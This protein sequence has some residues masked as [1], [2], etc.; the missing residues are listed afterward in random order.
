LD[1][2]YSDR[3]DRG[4][5]VRISLPKGMPKYRKCLKTNKTGESF[6]PGRGQLHFFT[7]QPKIENPDKTT[8]PG[9]KKANHKPSN[10]TGCNCARLTLPS[11]RFPITRLGDVNVIIN[12]ELPMKK[13]IIFFSFY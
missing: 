12:F 13:V 2:A 11:R 4:N 3:G 6:N 9:L 10:Q 5:A 8:C 1:S 7:G